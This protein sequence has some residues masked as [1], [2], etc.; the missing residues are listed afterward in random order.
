MMKEVQVAGVGSIGD[1]VIEFFSER[2]RGALTPFSV[3]ARRI[4]G[5]PKGSL[6]EF[7]RL[8]DLRRR[9]KCVCAPRLPAANRSSYAMPPRSSLTDRS[10]F[11]CRGVACEAP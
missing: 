11:V 2:R 4:L 5:G 6:K 8:G 10:R 1:Y 7:K 3:P 9:G